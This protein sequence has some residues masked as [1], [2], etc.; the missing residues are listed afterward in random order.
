MT[1]YFNSQYS[2]LSYEFQKGISQKKTSLWNTAEKNKGQG[3]TIGKKLPRFIVAEVLLFLI[4]IHLGIPFVLRNFLIWMQ[5]TQSVVAGQLETLEIQ[6]ERSII[7]VK[8]HT[9]MLAMPLVTDL[10][11]IRH[12]VM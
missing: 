8:L 1:F 11:W 12:T 2:V 4:C 7:I 6:G 3:E 10:F 5:E 9:L